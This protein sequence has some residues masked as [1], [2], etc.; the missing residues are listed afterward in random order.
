MS[1][2]R[3][4]TPVVS[5]CRAVTASL[6]TLRRAGMRSAHGSAMCARS[7][8]APIAAWCADP[9]PAGSEA[10][11]VRGAVEPTPALSVLPQSVR[12]AVQPTPALSISPQSVRGAVKPTPALS[13]SPQSVRGAVEPTPTS[14]AKLLE[15]SCG[16]P[17]CVCPPD[18]NLRTTVRKLPL[19]GPST[20]AAG[21]APPRAR[22]NRTACPS[23]G[24][25]RRNLSLSTRP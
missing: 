4:T 24:Q 3:G 12:G 5:D 8:C 18:G 1:V 13:I 10:A 17:S 7:G 22:R 16:D 19:A 14:R 2:R 23:H 15:P 25:M 11:Q 9:L 20:C 6:L 21:S